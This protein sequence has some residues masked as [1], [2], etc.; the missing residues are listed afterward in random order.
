MKRLKA[1]PSTTLA[2]AQPPLLHLWRP[3]ARP[4]PETLGGRLALALR[5]FVS[6]EELPLRAHAGILA[7]AIRVL[8]IPRRSLDGSP[9]ASARRVRP[10]GRAADPNSAPLVYTER[11]G[12]VRFPPKARADGPLP[13]PVRPLRATSRGRGGATFL[14][15]GR[16]EAP[17]LHHDAPILRITTSL[18]AYFDQPLDRGEAHGPNACLVHRAWESP[19][20]A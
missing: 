10:H 15:R 18:E 3:S 7:I 12:H 16:A 9:S 14:V 19:E 6:G 4:R 20:H 8:I 13:R 1:Q 5:W 2:I 11:C 17:P